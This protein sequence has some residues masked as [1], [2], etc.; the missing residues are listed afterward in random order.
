[1]TREAILQN[2]K[3]K[4]Q[5]SLMNTPFGFISIK[6]IHINIFFSRIDETNGIF[7]LMRDYNVIL[8]DNRENIVILITVTR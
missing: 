4:D 5:M 7:G 2:K 3:E 8:Y 6:F 1:M